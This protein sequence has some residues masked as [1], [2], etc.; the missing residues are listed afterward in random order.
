MMMAVFKPKR[1]D[2]S[3]KKTELGRKLFYIIQSKG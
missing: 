3:M 1:A 2:D